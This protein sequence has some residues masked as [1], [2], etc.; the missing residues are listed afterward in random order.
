MKQAKLFLWVS[1][2]L[3]SL[4]GIHCK[5]EEPMEEM[6]STSP[7]RAV[8]RA[9]AVLHSTEGNDVQGIVSF[10][11]VEKGIQIIANVNGLSPG[12][13]GFH[14]HEYGDCSALDGTS[15]GGHF[16]PENML[17]G[18]PTDR[19]RHA[20]DLGNLE[21]DMEGKAHYERI[22]DR[23]SLVGPHS[24]IGL[25]VIVHGGEDD[26]TTQPTGN[27]GPRVACGVIGTAKPQK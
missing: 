8:T 26:F 13:H 21:A 11:E 27:A 6:V 25:A 23:I 22:D 17:H 15:A 24:I 19:E 10:T 3:I 14:I 5:S 12:K 16:N 20:G 4:S 7:E 2:F 18:G 9:V 1:V